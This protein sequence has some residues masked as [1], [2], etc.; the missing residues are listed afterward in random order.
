MSSVDACR[1]RGISFRVSSSR[2]KFPSMRLVGL[3]GHSM[4][5][6]HVDVNHRLRSSS[7]CAA[8][9][10]RGRFSAFLRQALSHADCRDERFAGIGLRILDCHIRPLQPVVQASPCSRDWTRQM[11]RIQPP[12]PTLHDLLDDPGM[13][14]PGF[15]PYSVEDEHG[16]LVNSACE[17]VSGPLSTSDSDVLEHQAI[18]AATRSRRSA[19]A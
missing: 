14:Q 9:R 8:W 12:M 6:P 10:A 2:G 16:L 18:H 1:L 15:L 7:G 5:M 19:C 4:C 17:R 11:F 3:M 13:L